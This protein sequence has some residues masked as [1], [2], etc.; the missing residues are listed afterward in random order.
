MD[1]VGTKALV[2]FTWR[3]EHIVRSSVLGGHDLI[4]LKP[5]IGIWVSRTNAMAFSAV[6]VPSE[7]KPTRPVAVSD[8][9]SGLALQNV[10]G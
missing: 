10:G 1:R 2:E 6:S 4:R 7:S 3:V 8:C 5:M 9:P